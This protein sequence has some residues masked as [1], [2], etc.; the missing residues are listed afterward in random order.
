LIKDKSLLIKQN[1][2]QNIELAS[3]EECLKSKKAILLSN[4]KIIEQESNKFYASRIFQNLGENTLVVNPPFPPMSENE[5][6]ASFDL[7][8]TRLPHPK[9]KKRGIIPA[10]EMDKTFC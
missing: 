3:H 9:Y 2:G 5:I 8:Y 1:N 6:D 4:F 10:Y 7:P